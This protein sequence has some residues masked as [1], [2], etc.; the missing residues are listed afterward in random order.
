MREKALTES[1]IRHLELSP[2]LQVPAGISVS[3]VLQLMRTRQQTCAL[4]CE[5]ASCEGIFTERDFLLKLCGKNVDLS[6][7]VEQ[8]MTHNPKTLTPEDTVGAAIELMDQFGF[9]N[10]PLV[11]ADGRFS[12]LVQIRDIINFLA[13]LYPQEVLNAPPRPEQT[14]PQPD[15]A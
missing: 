3:E 14:F 9:R 2:P 11:D 7:P 10:V 13:E 6:A 15:G 12:G 8:F 1:K 4:I 5:G